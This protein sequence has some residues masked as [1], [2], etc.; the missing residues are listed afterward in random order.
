M[1]H[2]LLKSI[3]Q[4]I[5]AAFTSRIVKTDNKIGHCSVG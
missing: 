4:M 2:H 3:G 1:L 5:G